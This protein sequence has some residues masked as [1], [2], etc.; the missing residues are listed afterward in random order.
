MR[1]VIII[2]IT[3][4]S[5]FQLYGKELSELNHFLKRYGNFKKLSANFKG[6]KFLK[7]F[8]ATIKS[9]GK[10][11]VNRPDSLTWKI[12]R[13]VPTTYEFT[14]NSL[15]IFEDGKLSQN[16]DIAKLGPGAHKSIGG[17]MAWLKLDSKTIEKYYFVSRSGKDQ[18]SFTYKESDPP[19][20]KI[21]ATL[22]PK[23]YISKVEITELS[24]DV[25]TLTFERPEIIRE[26][27]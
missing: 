25:L 5:C 27:I 23:G 7:R 13:P 6:E 21:L 3:T 9:E 26:K 24:G 8:D 18:F 22:A 11:I 17:L 2:L 4:L 19:F 10:L 12:L 16:L 14:K 1:R 20:K 15:K